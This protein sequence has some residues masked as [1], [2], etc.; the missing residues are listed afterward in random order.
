MTVQVSITNRV[1]LQKL[2]ANFNKPEVTAYTTAAFPSPLIMKTNKKTTLDGA[3]ADLTRASFYN[4]II[5]SYRCGKEKTSNPAIKVFSNGTLHITGLK[6]ITEALAVS[7][8]FC[9]IFELVSGEDFGGREPPLVKDFIVKDFKGQE[10]FS[11]E[12]FGGREPPLVKDFIVEDFRVQL[13]NSHFKVPSLPHISLDKLHRH[14]LT[15][16]QHLCRYNREN[17][18]GLIIRMDLDTPGATT[19]RHIS[20]IIFES[21]NVIISAFTHSSELIRAYEFVVGFL[22]KHAASVAEADAPE[23]TAPSVKRR[24]RT[25]EGFDYGKYIML[26]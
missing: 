1:S 17:H 5:F 8:L 3:Q 12:D 14:L 19:L 18:A 23:A 13:V 24:R 4:C 6:T 21:G 11:V 9:K 25:V 20:V 26:K 2:N 7:E 15:E 22:K 10:P 16:T